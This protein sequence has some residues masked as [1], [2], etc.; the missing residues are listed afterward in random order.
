MSFPSGKQWRLWDFH[1]EFRFPEKMGV[2]MRYQMVVDVVSPT[3]SEIIAEV[4]KEC[5][6]KI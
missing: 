4:V 2:G 5:Y 3:I 1:H 6:V